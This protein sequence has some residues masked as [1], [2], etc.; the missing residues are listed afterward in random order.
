MSVGIGRCF[1]IKKE[2]PPPEPLEAYSAF[3]LPLFPEAADVIVTVVPVTHQSHTTFAKRDGIHIAMEMAC[4][5][6]LLL[7]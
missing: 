4:V 2:R 3:S 7:V 5:I 6:V 1:A